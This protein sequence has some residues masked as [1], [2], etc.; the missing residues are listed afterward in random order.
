MKKRSRKRNN[1]LIKKQVVVGD[2][3]FRIF[4]KT[5]G[6]RRPIRETKMGFHKP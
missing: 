5:G 1:I 4:Q 2:K 3:G 6:F